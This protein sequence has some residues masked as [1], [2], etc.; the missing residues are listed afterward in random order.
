MEI[1]LTKVRCTVVGFGSTIP[2]VL[3]RSWP[4]LFSQVGVTK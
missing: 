4:R 2:R 3:T 1:T